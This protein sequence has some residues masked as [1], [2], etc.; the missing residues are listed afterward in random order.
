MP[1]LE[2]PVFEGDNPRW[3]VRKCERMFDWYDIP[4]VRR[5]PLAAAYFDDVVDAWY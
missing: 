5:V 4:E 1:R 3:W 2:I